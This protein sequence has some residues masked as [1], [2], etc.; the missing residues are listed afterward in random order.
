MIG[1]YRDDRAS[2]FHLIFLQDE[3]LP[4]QRD[5]TRQRS[6]EDRF[7]NYSVAVNASAAAAFL[8]NVRF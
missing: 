7:G 3:T 5:G 1:E 8:K 2:S 6:R 4:G